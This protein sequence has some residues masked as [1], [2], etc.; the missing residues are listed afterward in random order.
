[1]KM[2]SI[3]IASISLLASVITASLSYYFTKKHQLKIEGRRRK[4][5]Y[6]KS[7][8]KALSDVTISNKDSEA[9]RRLS[10]GFNSLIV[11]GSPTVVKKL[12][13]F[14]EF[15]RAENLQ[16]HRNSNEWAIQHDIL[17]R[18]AIKEMRQDIF[19][20]EKNIDD[21]LAN[22]HLVGRERK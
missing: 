16:Q 1:M 11:I 10:E 7:F 21:Y 15:V 22:V 4:E 3:I 20:K 6:Y 2:E 12:M 19:G 17:L 13:E 14:H 8:V 5:E 9:Q 18:A